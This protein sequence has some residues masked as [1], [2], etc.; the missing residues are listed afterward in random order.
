M[1]RLL[2]LFLCGPLAA[3][4][5]QGQTLPEPSLSP[6][7]Q[8]SAFIL[9]LRTDLMEQLARE[10][11]IRDQQ[12]LA[13]LD[14]RN[15]F[16][17]VTLGTHLKF[18][19]QVKMEWKEGDDR[20]YRRLTDQLAIN[21]MPLTEIVYGFHKTY[22]QHIYLT[23]PGI[24]NSRQMLKFFQSVYGPGERVYEE[25]VEFDNMIQW[26]GKKVVL[27]Y[28]EVA[29][30][31]EGFFHFFAIDGDLPPKPAPK[32]VPKTKAPVK[33]AKPKAAPASKPAPAKAAVS[34]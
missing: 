8:D 21:G 12:L 6:A 4:L 30:K 33:K 25:T 20:N 32:P 31:K 1:K 23:A 7:L 15:G 14:K 2:T 5:A 17:D 3:L 29:S 22:L 34:R 13:K 19:K 27:T 24:E 28:S 18:F 10:Q 16:R 26:T 9:P 11:E